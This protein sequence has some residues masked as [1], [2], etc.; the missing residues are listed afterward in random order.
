MKDF[1][2]KVAV[3]TGSTQG[4]GEAT[5]RLFAQRGIRGLIITGRNTER[6]HAVATSLCNDVTKAVFVPADLAKLD[7]CTKIIQAAD[8][9]FG[10][11]H[12]L[13]NAAALT[14]R[15][16][17]WDTTPELYDAMMNINCR[18]PFF[19][20]QEAAR[21]MERDKVEGSIVNISSNASFGSMPASPP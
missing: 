14:A 20:M 3:I 13:V 7:E 12:I 16:S 5:A 17:V 6:G 8:D 2:D 11:L 9:H 15:A 21:I 1:K 19:L 18:A 4:L 10:S